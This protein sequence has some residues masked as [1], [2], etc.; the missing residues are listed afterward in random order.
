MVPEQKTVLVVDDTP[1]NIQ[2]V[3][4]TLADLCKVRVANSGPRALA[5]IEKGPLPDL[6]LLDIMMPEMDGYEVCRRLKA[7]PLTRAIPVIFLT[8]MTQA[9][10]ETRGFDEG[11]VD[12]IHKP[13]SPSV[14]LARTRTQL[15]LREAHENLAREKALVENLLASLLPGAAV[16]ELKTRGTVEPRR[17]EEVA[18]LFC[19][20]VDFTSYCSERSPAEVVSALEQLFGLF[21]ACARE[22]G[23]EKI[24]TIGD[25]FLATAG[26]LEPCP[27]PLRSGLECARA[28][29]RAAAGLGW[30]MRAGLYQGPVMAGV[31]GRERYQ[32]DIWGDTVNLAARLAAAGTAGRVTMVRAQGERLGVALHD[33]GE[34]ALK[35]KGANHLVEV[36]S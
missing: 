17:F 16:A 8:A 4:N 20:L 5:L 34:V 21:E 36:S 2:V 33:L 3:A 18:V 31:V 14:L 24:K 13:I 26:L 9:E 29:N 30:Q 32:Y 10:N 23:L 27:D 35:G 25:A 28:I 22:H 19:D 11:A 6:I 12:Y 7:D 15:S 1:E